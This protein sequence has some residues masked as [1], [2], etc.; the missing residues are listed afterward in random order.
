MIIPILNNGQARH[1]CPVLAIS[2]SGDC[3]SSV[4]VK[5]SHQSVAFNASDTDRGLIVPDTSQRA[6][7]WCGAQDLCPKGIWISSQT[8]ELLQE[9]NPLSNVSV[10]TFVKGIYAVHLGSR[11]TVFAIMKLSAKLLTCN[12][13]PQIVPP[14]PQQS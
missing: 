9:C 8:L 12:F 6:S 4:L 2:P 5:A 13:G 10:M 3:M 1:T 7:T 14:F 11:V